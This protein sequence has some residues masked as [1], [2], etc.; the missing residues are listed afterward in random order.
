MVVSFIGAGEIEVPGDNLRHVAMNG[1]RTHNVS[2]VDYY[3][4]HHTNA[5]RKYPFDQIF[6]LSCRAVDILKML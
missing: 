6:A 4:P 2:G 5:N 1:I 3:I